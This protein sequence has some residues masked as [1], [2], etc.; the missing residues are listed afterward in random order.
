MVGLATAG[1]LVVKTLL[2]IV[3]VLA[4]DKSNLEP[5]EMVVALNGI[6]KQLKCVNYTHNPVVLIMNPYLRTGYAGANRIAQAHSSV[7]G[8]VEY[9][10]IRSGTW[11]LRTPLGPLNLLLSL[12]GL[13]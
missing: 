13:I 9:I 4:W 10:V 3:N 5:G 7:A 12:G 11:G 2:G 6:L 1:A 8:H